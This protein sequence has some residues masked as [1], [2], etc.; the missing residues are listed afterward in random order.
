MNSV[1]HPV[2][3]EALNAAVMRVPRPGTRRD[4]QLAVVPGKAH[5]VIGMRRSG[6]TTFLF[7]LHAERLAG[8][9]PAE[10][11]LYLN[12]DDERLAELPLEQLNSL[13]EEY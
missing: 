11:T 4:A 8:G 6:K 3:H 1:L 2:L 10:R 7:Q 12:F 13:V 9:Q 5:A